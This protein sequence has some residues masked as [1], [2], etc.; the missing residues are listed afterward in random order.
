MAAYKVTASGKRDF[1]LVADELVLGTLQYTEWFSFKA[2]ITLADGSTFQIAP[3]GAWGTTIEVKAHD[4]VVLNFRMNWG[5][6][7]LIKSRIHRKAFIFKQ[8][9]LFK[10]TYILQDKDGQEMLTIQ[11]DF[12]WSNINHDY[13]L[14]ATAEFDA[15]DNHALLLLTTV[16]CANYYMSIVTGMTVIAATA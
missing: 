16:H 14:S 11:P 9:S 3:R 15:F 13:S 12:K 6:N 10:N 1:Q 2:V 5:G 4:T 7:I 8:K